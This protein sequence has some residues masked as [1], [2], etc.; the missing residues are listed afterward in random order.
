MKRIR[1]PMHRYGEA[2]FDRDYLRWGFHDEETQAREADSVLRIAGGEGPL[3]ILDLA[4]G[5]GVHAVRW[6]KRGH[7]VT[8]V[9]LSETFIAHA[10][11]SAARE[12]VEAELVVADIRSFAPDSAFDVVSWIENSFFDADVLARIRGCL[13]PGGCFVLDVR[14]PEHPKVKA[15]RGNWRTWR[16]ENGVS[17]WSG[18]RPTPRRAYTKTCG[19]PST[20]GVASSRSGP[21][22]TNTR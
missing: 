9:D 12:G 18:T 13:R 7:R 5:T 15:R 19:S 8:G 17:T 3:R 14:N 21:T 22:P 6:A 1:M 16:E 11:E 20:R 4:C 2:D 10:R